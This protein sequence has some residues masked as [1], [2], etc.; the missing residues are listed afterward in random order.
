MQALQAAGRSEADLEGN[1]ALLEVAIGN[2]KYPFLVAARD[3]QVGCLVTA[4]WPV[5]A[6]PAWFA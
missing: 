6:L 3:V 4:C 5:V 1:T 2:W